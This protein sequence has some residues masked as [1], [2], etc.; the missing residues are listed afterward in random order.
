MG[1]MGFTS[2]KVSNSEGVGSRYQMAVSL[3]AA[4]FEI[5]SSALCLANLE[6]ATE[7]GLTKN[8]EC[9]LCLDSAILS[10]ILMLEAQ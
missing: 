2:I 10:K 7:N 3:G 1:N 4:D 5:Y 9:F 6:I 8:K